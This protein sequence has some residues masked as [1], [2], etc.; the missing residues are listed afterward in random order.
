MDQDGDG[1]VDIPLI[2]NMFGTTPTARITVIYGRK[3]QLP[4]TNDFETVTL[5]SANGFNSILSDVTGDGLPEI[6]V[7][8][9]GLDMVRIYA[10]RRGQRLK[11]QF[12]SGNDDPIPGKG[13]WR[14]P[15]AELWDA[16]KLNDGWIGSGFSPPFAY[17]GSLDSVNDI[18]LAS[19]PYF[20]CYTAGYRLDSLID[21]IIEVPQASAIGYLGDIDGSGVNAIAVRDDAVGGIIFFK[22][23]SAIGETHIYRKVPDEIAGV[24]VATTRSS[25]SGS[26][27]IYAVPNPA[28]KEVTISWQTDSETAAIVKV[29][30]ILG[31]EVA[32][33]HAPAGQQEVRWQSGDVVGGAYFITVTIGNRS[34]STRVIVR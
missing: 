34:D 23:T 7:D 8:C 18:W 19:Y 17:D 31:R 29:Q 16:G 4:D 5:D 11:E 27:R 15:W 21:G 9:G 28:H 32:T 3:G 24:G 2:H 30:D 33:L 22:A 13:W 12:G 20:L 25:A 14:R 26:L 1:N 10:G 6:L